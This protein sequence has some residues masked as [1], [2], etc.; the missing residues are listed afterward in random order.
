MPHDA[1]EFRDSGKVKQYRNLCYL[2]KICAAYLRKY[3]VGNRK[4]GLVKDKDQRSK[5]DKTTI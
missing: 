4:T 2:L 3:Q 5:M 1:M